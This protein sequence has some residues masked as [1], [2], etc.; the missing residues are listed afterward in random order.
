MVR[1]SD[2]INRVTDALNHL[3]HQNPHLHLG[4]LIYHVADVERWDN[5]FYVDDDQWTVWIEELLSEG[6]NNGGV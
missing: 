3:W 1:N 5:I 6:D 4:Q 2:R